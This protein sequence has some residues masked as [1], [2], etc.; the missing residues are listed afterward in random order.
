MGIDLQE[1]WQICVSSSV[2]Y[3]FVD[4]GTVFLAYIII[5]PR[6]NFDFLRF[7]TQMFYKDQYRTAQNFLFFNKTKWFAY[8]TLE[9]K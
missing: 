4:K 3:V 9:E 5:S 1:V 6:K 8:L 2:R 7:C